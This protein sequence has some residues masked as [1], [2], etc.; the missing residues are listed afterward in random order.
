MTKLTD[1]QLVLLSA[2]SRR[3]DGVIPVNK[4]AIC[5]RIGVEVR[6]RCKSLKSLLNL[7]IFARLRDQDWEPKGPKIRRL[8]TATST[9]MTHFRFSRLARAMPC[10]Q[11][12]PFRMEP[13]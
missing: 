6:P 9:G 10:R 3:T 5:P 8:F 2:A 7:I 4:Y 11:W 12:L 13:R 1:T